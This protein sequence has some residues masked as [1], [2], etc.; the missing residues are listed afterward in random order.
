MRSASLVVGLVFLVATPSSAQQAPPG[1]SAAEHAQFD[2]WVGSWTVTNP[3]NGATSGRS[4][5]EKVSTGCAILEHWTDARGTDGHSINF[6]DPDSGSW[7]QVWMG[8]NGAPL[9]LEGGSDRQ[10]RMVLS[11]QSRSPQG[12]V[13]NRVTWTRLDDGTVEQ[14]WETSSDEGATWTIAF[15]GIYQRVQ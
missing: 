14:R 3:S 2:F 7:H 11:G 4:R 5:I 6:Y 9:R 8:S 10:G 15:L 12:V 1:C 13:Q